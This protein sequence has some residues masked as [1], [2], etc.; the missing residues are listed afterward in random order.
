MKKKLT[1]T[2]ILTLLIIPVALRFTMNKRNII[3]S[4]NI[5][6]SIKHV[7]EFK[8]E[9]SV[10]NIGNFRVMLPKLANDFFS[11]H[12]AWGGFSFNARPADKDIWT[13][14]NCCRRR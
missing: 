8:I 3:T 7:E 5:K 6:L 13:H 1:W 11:K 12:G 2:F 10:E 9:L 14:V 4:E